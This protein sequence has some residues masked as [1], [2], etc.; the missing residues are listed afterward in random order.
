MMPHISPSRIISYVLF[1]STD[2]LVIRKEVYLLLNYLFNIALGETMDYYSSVIIFYGVS[3]PPTEGL[4]NLSKDTKSNRIIYRSIPFT[5]NM[6]CGKQITQSNV[7][8]TIGLRLRVT[9]KMN[10]KCLIKS[11]Y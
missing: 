8:A 7:E 10:T 5:Y 9:M 11:L 2:S 6:L 1:I 4:V 3:S